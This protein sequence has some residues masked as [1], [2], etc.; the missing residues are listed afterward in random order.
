[1]EAAD[2]SLFNLELNKRIA[3]KEEILKSN[4]VDDYEKEKIDWQISGMKLVSGM[5]NELFVSEKRNDIAK[6]S[7]K[8]YKVTFKD[9]KSEVVEGK[10]YLFSESAPQVPIT[11]DLNLYN[12]NLVQSIQEVYIEV[13]HNC[14]EP[15]E[16]TDL[17]ADG[18]AVANVKHCTECG[19]SN[20][21]QINK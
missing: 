7:L 5:V 18:G 16:V 12:A 4:D 14:S 9:G 11:N 3:M 10:V 1:M 19:W 15:I 6:N 13:C 8:T 2:K 17:Y 20:G 21:G